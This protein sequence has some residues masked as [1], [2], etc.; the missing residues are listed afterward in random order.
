M[1]RVMWIAALATMVSV[2]GTGKSSA[3]EPLEGL[4]G[5]IAR[6]SASCSDE[7]VVRTMVVEVKR[8]MATAQLCDE[9]SVKRL[10]SPDLAPL[11]RGCNAMET[12]FL[13][14]YASLLADPE[15]T[16]ISCADGLSLVSTANKAFR[17]A[18]NE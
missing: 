8:A 15:K 4:S 12:S 1:M 6:D 11:D 9:T 17:D 10:L 3:E 5:L 2:G 16:E 18:M 13:T 7:S 14:S